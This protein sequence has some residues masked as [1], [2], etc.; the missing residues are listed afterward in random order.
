MPQID[1]SLLLLDVLRYV[2]CYVSCTQ[3]TSLQKHVQLVGG[4]IIFP[5]K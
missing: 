1:E 5:H 4:E 2:M 3:T